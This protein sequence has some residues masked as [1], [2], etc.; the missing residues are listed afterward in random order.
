MM[1]N[2]ENDD[3]RQE[4]CEH[5]QRTH[6]QIKLI[7]DDPSLLEEKVQEFYEGW[8]LFD[9][10][11]ED[12]VCDFIA[13]DCSFERVFQDSRWNTDNMNDRLNYVITTNINEYSEEYEE[14][15]RWIVKKYSLYP[16]AKL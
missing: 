14:V 13:N 15:P 2:I 9:E 7:K 8:K 1:K 4:W 16:N 11:T 3:N 12:F 6:P 5:R 10:I